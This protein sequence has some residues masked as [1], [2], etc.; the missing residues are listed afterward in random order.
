[1]RVVTMAFIEVYFYFLVSLSIL[2]ALSSHWFPL[3]VYLNAILLF[4]MLYLQIVSIPLQLNWSRNMYAGLLRRQFFLVGYTAIIYATHFYFGGIIETDGK[5]ASFVDALYFSFTTWTT[6]GYGDLTVV[7]QLRLATSLEALTGVFTI[8]VLTALI[9]L[10][11]QERL[12]PKSADV[13]KHGEFRL[14][15]D[16]ALGLWREVESQEVL[17]YTKLRARSTTLQI[18]PKCGQ[19]PKMDKFFDIVGRLAP[20]AWFIVVCNCGAH[21]KP[22]RNAYL[23]ERKWNINGPIVPKKHSTLGPRFMLFIIIPTARFA[24][25]I[26]SPLSRALAR[27]HKK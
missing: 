17:E 24:S 8:T 14:Q 25:A 16:Q 26:V 18:C 10:Y 1:M 27:R 15:L 13:D 19:S 20:F 3:L 22:R 11:C 2:L 7:H 12:Q 23:A 5:Q 4:L 9:W 21:S 6:L